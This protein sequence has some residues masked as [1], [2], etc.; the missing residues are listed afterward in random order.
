VGAREVPVGHPPR[1]PIPI[2]ALDEAAM[3][4]ARERLPG[5]ELAAWLAGVTASERPELRV[6][7]LV[8]EALPGTGL[9]VGEVA[10]GVD[11]GRDLA[12]RAAAVVVTVLAGG[13][14]GDLATARRLA[15]NAGRPLRALRRLGDFELTVLCGLALGA[16]E[17]GLGYVCD[18]LAA[19]AAAA[20]AV[21]IEPDVG[22][23]LLAARRPGEPADDALLER[24]GLEP[25][26]N[27]E[28]ALRR[29][30]GAAAVLS[31][32]GRASP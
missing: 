12:A 5:D 31:G 20:V 28:T 14:A 27:L 8:P 9:S 23:R 3:A 2:V 22:P 25:L 19:T 11:R 7:V 32:W 13:G 1:P 16:G 30:R 18:G 6:R 21:G 15:A 4:A 26:P 29:L 24:L 17:H 10:A